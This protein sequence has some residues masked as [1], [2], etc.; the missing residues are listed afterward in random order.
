MC[1][2]GL[3]MRIKEYDVTA[4]RGCKHMYIYTY[5][6]YIYIT[7]VYAHILYAY[8]IHMHICMYTH[9]Y[10]DMGWLRLVDSLKL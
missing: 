4:V 5:S 8:T 10:T 7:Q 6:A 2:V 9:V 1:A 3:G